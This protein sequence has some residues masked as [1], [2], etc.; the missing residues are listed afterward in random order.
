MDTAVREKVE[1][2]YPIEV[3]GVTVSVLSLRRPRVRDR[4]AAEKLGK[5]D[6]EKEI[7]LIALLAEI[8]HEA[9]HEL[10]MGDYSAVQQALTGF[11]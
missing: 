2:K 5:S 6:A 3:D 1:L 9:L 10:D 11:F 8:P 4:L 7:A